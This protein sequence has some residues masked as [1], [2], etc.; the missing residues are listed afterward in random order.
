MFAYT[1]PDGLPS[2]SR[3]VWSQLPLQPLT[4]GVLTPFSYSVLDEIA[5]GAWYQYYD[6]LDFA[7]MPRARVLRRYQGGTYLNLT[8]SAQREVDFAAVEPLTLMIDDKAFPLVKWEKPGLFAG[9]KAGRNRKKIA[10]QLIT[11]GQAIDTI[12]QKAAA[13]YFRTQELRWTQADVLQIMEEI[14]RVGRDSFKLFFGARHNLELIY[15]HLLKL[16]GTQQTLPA[17]LALL[18]GALCDLTDL[19]EYQIADELFRLGEMAT[20]DPA[21]TNWLQLRDYTNWQ[22]ALP[23]KRLV[24]ACV[25]FMRRNGHRCVDEAEIRQPRWQEDPS[26]FF[27]SLHAFVKKHPKHPTKLPSTQ[28]MQRLLDIM[29]PSERQGAQNLVGQ[30]RQLLKLQSH[31]LHAFAYILAG[32]RS[33]ALAAAKEAMADGRLQQSDDLFFFELEEIKQMMTGEWNVSARREIHATCAQRRAEF[34]QWQSSSPPPLLI[35][36]SG[37]QPQYQGLPGSSG[38]A[39]GPLRRW[40]HPA[41]ASCNGAIVGTQHLDSGW[42]LILPFARALVVA[43]GASLDPIV[44]AARSWHVPTV[45]GLGTRYGALMEGAQTTVHGDSGLVEQ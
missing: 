25:D 23:N 14:E 38:H 24:D 37:A 41:P 45:L 30:M 16:M 42:A 43:N 40:E 13:W 28:N 7:P 20:N 21:T 29:V 35:G 32:T 11:Y 36:D 17:N 5:R 8:I 9:I 18:Q 3:T 44:A 34:A 39:I 22:Q 12:T 33:W 10:T 4:A 31:A 19:V 27:A 26:L 6:E 15:S 2:G 1:L